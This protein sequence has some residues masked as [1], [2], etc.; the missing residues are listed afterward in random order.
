MKQIFPLLLLIVYSFQL[1]AEDTT[2][3]KAD[4]PYIQYTGRTDISQPDAPRFWQPGVY[5]RIK[6]KGRYCNI[7]IDDEVRYGKEHN[8]LAIQVDNLPV[9]RLQTT[10]AHNIINAADD[11]SNSE[12]ILTICKNT[13]AAIGYLK[14]IGVQCSAILPLPAKPSRKIEFI[15]N[16]I[17]CGTGS[18][19]SVVP[20]EKGVWYD[21]HN[22]W[23]SYGPTTA[24]ALKAQWHLSSVSGIGLTRSCCD[25]NITMPQVFD[26]IDMRTAELNW[27]FK[28]Y[29]PDVVTVCLGQNDGKQDSV[30]YCKAYLQFID[31][32]RKEYPKATIICLSSPMADADLTAVMQRYLKAIVTTAHDKNVY[33][34]FFSKRYHHGCGDHP[35]L[36]EHKQIAAELTAYIGKIKKWQRS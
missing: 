9:K 27:D 25:M 28:R 35:D 16:S 30:I 22:A 7:I 36:E 15:G 10:G 24:R 1:K 34:Y 11:L 19:Q 32:L 29:Q 5:I 23:M 18:D 4:H 6:F 14:F 33:R 2:F 20:C 31:T 8:Y 12:H 17:T 26:K 21:Q 13:E 3:F